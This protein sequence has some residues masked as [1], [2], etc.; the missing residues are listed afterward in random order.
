MIV[1]ATLTHRPSVRRAFTL[2]E[3]L[4]A[5]TLCLVIM[6]ILST[7][8]VIGTQAFSEFK[9]GGDLQEE[10]RT[11]SI[12][13][14]RDLAA[15]H[16]N[17][18]TD[19]LIKAVGGPY[20]HQ[21]KINLVSWVQPEIGYVRFDSST[22][23]QEAT[24]GLGLVS[25]YAATHWMQFTVNLDGNR[26]E[27]LFVT[28]IGGN[29]AISNLSPSPFRDPANQVFYSDWADVRYFLT[30]MP[31]TTLEGGTKLYRLHRQQRLA[32]PT[33]AVGLL[34]VTTN[35]E[36]AT[37]ATGV[38]LRANELASKLPKLLAFPGVQPATLRDP[39]G[40]DILLTNVVAFE[41]K[42]YWLPPPVPPL[43]GPLTGGLQPTADF[44]YGFV[45]RIFDTTNPLDRIRILGLQL[46]IRVYDTNTGLT[47]QV[48]II[49]DL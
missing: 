6:S 15:R 14:K 44:P 13:I 28:N 10:L 46:R 7:A 34:P 17:T 41:I 24:D 5:L 48:T 37:D 27:D 16:F 39:E 21:Q 2:V 25:S 45:G 18:P 31:T 38:M 8:F 22:P 30:E 47:R 3:L 9:S 43:T 23:L 26:L 20:L 49:Q 36:I 29:A 33:G 32:A 40:R 42:A 19:P 4:V 1:A 12:V 35:P 11:A